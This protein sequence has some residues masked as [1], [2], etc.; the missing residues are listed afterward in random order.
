MNLPAP[1]SIWQKT[2]QNQART[3]LGFSADAVWHTVMSM[4][5]ASSK[6]AACPKEYRY[7][8]PSKRFRPNGSGPFFSVSVSNKAEQRAADTRLK[9]L[10]DSRGNL[11]L[12]YLSVI[13]KNGGRKLC[14][15]NIWPLLPFL[16]RRLPAV[17]TMT[18]SAPPQVRLQVPLSSVSWAAACSQGRLS[19]LALVRCATISA[20][21]TKLTNI[22]RS[23]AF[24]RTYI[25][26]TT[27]A[28]HALCG[29][30][31]CFGGRQTTAAFAG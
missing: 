19:G 10:E 2:A 11:S 25:T 1:S 23:R 15:S 8:S 22:T 17:W 16:S 18:L 7:P 28:G 24:S 30:F 12:L 29:G 4:A 6:A 3:S 13:I 21:A 20:C 14:R 26:K 5:V 31:L 27:I 9:N